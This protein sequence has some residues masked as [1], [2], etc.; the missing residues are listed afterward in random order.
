MYSKAQIMKAAWAGY[1]ARRDRY[2][3]M[4]GHR[5]AFSR[6]DFSVFLAA[7]WRQAR[8]AQMTSTERAQVVKERVKAL[9]NLSGGYKMTCIRERAAAIAAAIAA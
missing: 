7:A 1:N 8:E 5:V 4:R 6:S 2:S 9:H 3:K